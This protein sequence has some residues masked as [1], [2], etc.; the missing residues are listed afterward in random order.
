MPKALPR[1][2]FYGLAEI[3]ARW[4]LQEADI[5]SYVLEGELTL[6][7]PVA[8]LRVDTFEDEE[9]CDGRHF[10]IPTGTRSIT[11]TMDL[12][13]V[14]AWTVMQHASQPV[15]YFYGAA[16]GEYFDL[17]DQDD[18]PGALVVERQALVVR[19]AEMER[20]EELHGIGDAAV[21]AGELRRA[22]AL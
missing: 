20:F 11:G 12:S 7:I 14:D 4:S 22:A 3:C 17:P 6:S 16:P 1:K 21:V 9:D 19:R 2:P 18:Q 10:R 8:G 13:R 15:A 5:A